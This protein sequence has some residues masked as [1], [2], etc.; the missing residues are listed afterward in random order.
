[1]TYFV[2]IIVFYH[3]FYYT[4]R[5]LDYLKLITPHAAIFYQLSLYNELLLMNWTMYQREIMSTS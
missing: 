5:K 3:L 1:M 4:P 2:K